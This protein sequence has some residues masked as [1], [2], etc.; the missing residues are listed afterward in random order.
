MSK[1][2]WGYDAAFLEACRE[3]LTVTMA[4]LEIG[5]IQV[6]SEGSALL[7]L[8][9]VSLEA[10]DC[11]L[12]KLFVTPTAMGHG[13]GRALF[14]WSVDTARALGARRLIVEADPGA[15]AFYRRMNC[16]DA[17]EVLSG[18]LPGRKLPRLVYVL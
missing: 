13:V 16:E 8:V 15:R 1:A 2:H 11:S 7:G 17:G 12:E 9:Q 3:E 18:S 5:H 6:A 10:D 4:D 14:V